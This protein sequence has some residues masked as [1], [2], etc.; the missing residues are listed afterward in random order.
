[1]GLVTDARLFELIMEIIENEYDGLVFVPELN[2]FVR[3]D[4]GFRKKVQ[5][6]LDFLP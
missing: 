6:A 2:M 4:T 5:N 1:M 3:I